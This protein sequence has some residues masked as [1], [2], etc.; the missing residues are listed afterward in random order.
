MPKYN[1]ALQ[2]DL[3]V[4]IFVWLNG[5]IQTNKHI[6]M[7]NRKQER[8][9]RWLFALCEGSICAPSAQTKHALNL[10]LYMVY[11]AFG[12]V[13]AINA[14]IE[15]N[16][17][18]CSFG[19]L[20]NEMCGGWFLRWCDALLVWLPFILYIGFLFVAWMS[21]RIL[22]PNAN[23]M[24]GT[25]KMISSKVW[26]EMQSTSEWCTHNRYFR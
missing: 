4:C 19:I 25:H 20:N 3:F 5:K 24:I 6:K 12:Y 11:A 15:E 16:I 23:R 14:L 18:Y 9:P 10:Q 1:I 17:S 21:W 26:I 7:F 8:S 2:W 13:D 22:S